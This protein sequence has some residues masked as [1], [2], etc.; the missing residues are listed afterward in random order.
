MECAPTFSAMTDSDTSKD[1][2]NEAMLN[3]DNDNFRSVQP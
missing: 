3:N 2:E 1:S